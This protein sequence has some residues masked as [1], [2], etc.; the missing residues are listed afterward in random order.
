MPGPSCASG[1]GA[2]AF[3]QGTPHARV[4]RARG[5]LDARLY[6]EIRERRRH[7]DP[8]PGVLGVL[9][10]CTD[11][12]GDP[13]PGALVRDQTTTLLFAGHD[14]RTA[15]LTARHP[16]PGA[17]PGTPDRGHP[18]ARAQGRAA[19]TVTTR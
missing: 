11:A 8:G 6:A 10:G 12:H 4:L 18:D 9:L 15:T 13:L 17:R 5:E 2:G 7:G 16:L 3:R 19:F 1:A 14:T